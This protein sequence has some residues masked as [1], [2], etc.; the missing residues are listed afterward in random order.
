MGEAAMS[1]RLRA[2][3]GTFLAAGA[4]FAAWPRIAATQALPQ[5]TIGT[6]PIDGAMGVVAALRAGYFHQYGLDASLSVANGAANAAA[7]TGGSLQFAASNIVTLIKAHLHGL[8][9]QVVAPGAIYS[10]DNPT[11][12]LV[13]PKNSPLHN[14]A[15]LNGKT[16]GTTSLGDILAQ[17]TLAWIDQHGGNSASVHLVEIPPTAI[18]AALHTGRIDAATLAEPHL[19][20]AVGDG[21]VVIFAKIF[22]AIAPRFAESAYF[23]MP[24]YIDANR[25]V[26]VRFA[27][28]ILAGNVFANE[29]PDRT[30]PW[31]VDSAKVDLASVKRSRREVFAAT[32]DPAQI[33]VVIDALVRM[34][35]IDRGFAAT[36]MI[37]PAVIGLRP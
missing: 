14:A 9:F 10:S 11:Q 29:H 3:R 32:V 13:V 1:L 28:A 2:S 37:S 35:A 16:I 8:P 25:E 21:S 23:A 22:D 30:A 6:S 7:V 20:E 33:Q 24:A 34:K 5:I 19:S 31:L 15:D 26:T 18:E 4:T 27:K 17:S 12:V 36:D